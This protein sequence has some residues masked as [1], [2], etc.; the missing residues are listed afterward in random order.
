MA[1]AAEAR[2]KLDVFDGEEEFFGAVVDEAEAVVR[3]GAYGEGFEAVVA[4]DAVILVDDEVALGDFG[5]FG[6][7][8]VGA[9]FAAR[10][11]GDAF[12]QKVLLADDGEILG[13]ETALE[14]EGDQ[15]DGAAGGFSGGGPVVAE[16]D[17]DGVFAEQGG[18]ALAGAAGPGGQNRAAAGGGPGL[19]L[20]AQLLEQ[21]VRGAGAGLGEDRAGAAAGIEARGVFRLGVGG[22]GQDLQRGQERGP[23]VAGEVEAVGG[24]RAVRGLAVAREGAAGVVVVGDH[25]QAGGEDFVGLVVERN[26][27]VREVVEQ[28]FHGGVEQRGPVLH[29]GVAAAVGDGVVDRVR[30]GGLAEQ[31]A[32]G[33]AEAGDAWF[34]RG[35]LR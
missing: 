4:A 35:G 1:F 3:G 9:L 20:V 11:A 15:G 6:N 33:G 8:L 26:R 13:E 14:G 16:G 32:P 10:G 29:A 22:E 21:I 12:A 34:C 5:G 31:V 19:H 27:G 30:G 17:F 25:F 7:E 24:E 28:G 2:Q 23:G 18:D